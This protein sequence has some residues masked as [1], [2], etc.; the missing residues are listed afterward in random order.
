MT[1]NDATCRPHAGLV[2]RVLQRLWVQLR[3]EE[4]VAA[5]L[6]KTAETALDGGRDLILHLAR[7]TVAKALRMQ[8]H[9]KK[10][11]LQDFRR[12]NPAL[13]YSPYVFRHSNC[14]R[15]ESQGVVEEEEEEE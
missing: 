10:M 15:R 1:V 6:R 11:H 9:L 13:S 8:C 4:D 2:S 7:Q 12:P 14:K 3:E 5:S